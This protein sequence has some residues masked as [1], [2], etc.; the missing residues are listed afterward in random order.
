MVRKYIRINGSRHYKNYDDAILKEA[1]DSIKRGK[2]NTREASEQFGIPHVTLHNHTT[3]DT[4]K[5]VGGQ[6][7]LSVQVE[8]ELVE[9][10]QTA[11][12]WGYPLEPMDIR[13]LVQKYLD[14]NNIQIVAFKDNLPGPDWV[15]YFLKRNRSSLTIRMSQ[16]VKRVRGAVLTEAIVAYFD[17]LKI[18]V[19]GIPARNIVNYDETNCTDDPGK[20]FCFCVV[21]V[22]YSFFF[23]I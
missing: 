8:R 5:N 13:L 6:T 11:A 3:K 23:N 16:N 15:S 9:V 12:D 18:S 21:C 17:C 22:N 10:L 19:D 20:K 7:A 14:S 1:V 4:I 2:L